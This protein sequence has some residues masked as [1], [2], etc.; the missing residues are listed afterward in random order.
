MHPKNMW[1]YQLVIKR[2]RWPAKEVVL[3][4]QNASTNILLYLIAMGQ[5]ATSSPSSNTPFLNI[6]TYSLLTHVPSGKT[7]N[8]CLFGS[9]VCS[10]NV[11]RTW[12]LSL[13]ELRSNQRHCRHPKTCCWIKLIRPVDFF[14]PMR[15][16]GPYVWSKTTA[17][18]RDEW[19]AT[20]TRYLARE[21]EG[22]APW[23]WMTPLQLITNA[24]DKNLIRKIPAALFCAL[25]SGRRKT[26]S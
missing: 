23:Y 1:T 7:S 10:I 26:C 3:L 5:I 9:L 2:N 17:S 20:K 21:R 14:W 16:Y 22:G 25:L 24:V 6:T 4:F 13:F 19:F 12:S 18:M 11:R 8:G 15:E